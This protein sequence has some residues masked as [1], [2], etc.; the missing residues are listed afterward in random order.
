M[1]VKD[2]YESLYSKGIISTYVFEARY[3]E[4]WGLPEFPL[5]DQ[6][7]L[8]REPFVDFVNYTYPAKQ[9]TGGPSVRPSVAEHPLPKAISQRAAAIVADWVRKTGEADG[10][11]NDD[12]QSPGLQPP[13]GAS[14]SGTHQLQDLGSTAESSQVRGRY[15]TT[16]R[17]IMDE[18][19]P[20]LGVEQ[21]VD[22]E[23]HGLRNESVQQESFQKRSAL[24]SLPGTTAQGITRPADDSPLES[25][26]TSTLTP[27]TTALADLVGLSIPITTNVGVPSGSAQHATHEHST[28]PPNMKA[29]G[30]G[31]DV[32]REGRNVSYTKDLLGTDN[33]D[34]LQNLMA[35]MIPTSAPQSGFGAAAPQREYRQTMNQRAPRR[36]RDR[37]P[38][39]PNA[40]ERLSPSPP[41]SVQRRSKIPVKSQPPTPSVRGSQLKTTQSTPGPGTGSPGPTKVNAAARGSRLRG[42]WNTGLGGDS[43]GHVGLTPELQDSVKMRIDFKRALEG[44][45]E[46]MLRRARVLPGKVSMEIVFCRIVIENVSEAVVNY[47]RVDQYDQKFAPLR[48]LNELAT[49]NEGDFRWHGTLSLNGGDANMLKEINWTSDANRKWQKHA[50]EV[51]YDFGCEDITNNCRFIIQVNA[52]DFTHSFESQKFALEDLVFIHCPDRSWDLNAC[53]KATDT[54]Y[55]KDQYDGFA[56]SLIESLAVP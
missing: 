28:Q 41:P 12:L 45:F 49:F 6:T 17:N 55:F 10:S 34:A 47:G 24:S 11:R 36:E 14:A 3:G 44:C 35:P 20:S 2:D 39:H 27:S 25:A 23:G 7:R 26:G 33:D 48:L 37:V 21:H 13:D 38:Q 51:F 18:D 43:F 32:Q 56:K 29:S 40:A 46:R 1:N 54:A 9:A 50:T 5:T 15:G 42:T 22:I 52:A 53:V 19:S 4:E 8:P 30:N 16:V 31:Y